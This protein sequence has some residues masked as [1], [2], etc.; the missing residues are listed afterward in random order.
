MKTKRN[1]TIA[2]VGIL[3][4]GWLLIPLS[5]VNADT[6]DGQTQM[7]IGEWTG[8]WPG[9]HGD[10]STLVIHEIDTEKAKA[11]C[12]YTSP[13]GTFPVTADYTPG[14]N[15]KLTFKLD[16][17]EFQF[18][19]YDNLLKATFEGDVRGMNLSNRTDM[20]KKPKK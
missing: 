15:P 18:V 4:V 10:E 12:T 1:M 14:P 6:T 9:I 19:L 3:I 8:V 20:G 5:R 7:L 17:G 16:Y 13:R 2:F 11:R